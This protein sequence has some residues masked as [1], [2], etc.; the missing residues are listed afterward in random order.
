MLAHFAHN[1]FMSRFSII[2]FII[3]FNLKIFCFYRKKANYSKMHPSFDKC[4]RWI[5]LKQK[6]MDK[7]R[8]I[9]DLLKP[10]KTHN[11]PIPCCDLLNG[12]S[13]TSKILQTLSS[14]NSSICLSKRSLSLIIPK[15]PTHN[16]ASHPTQICLTQNR[17]TAFLK[18]KK[19]SAVSTR[20]GKSGFGVDEIL[21]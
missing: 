8:I 19:A 15:N 1:I 6:N 4:T 9:S 13:F 18:K 5:I 11:R 14:L 20:R 2:T 16:Q 21:R 12:S 17:S 10:K 7:L 3:S